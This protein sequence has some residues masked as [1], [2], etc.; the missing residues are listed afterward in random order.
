MDS[1]DRRRVVVPGGSLR[2]SSWLTAERLNVKAL[3][4]TNVAMIAKPLFNQ[5]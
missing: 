4:G 2:E 1:L 5:C 3:H